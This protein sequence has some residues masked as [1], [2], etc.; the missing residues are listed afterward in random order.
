MA[1]ATHV[2]IVEVGPRDGLQNEP[3]TI[4][5]DDKITFVNLLSAANTISKLLVLSRPVGSAPDGA[6]VFEGITRRS[7]GEYSALVPNMYG[8]ERALK[9]GLDESL[10]SLRRARHSISTTST[11]RSM[12]A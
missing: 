8:L 4:S 3:E 10:S 11:H 7:D 5:T 12:K 2:K 6:D 9:A 1:F